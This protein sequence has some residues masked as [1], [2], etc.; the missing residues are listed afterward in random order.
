MV[1]LTLAVAAVVATL[2]TLL[3]WAARPPGDAGV[4]EWAARYD[5]ALRLEDREPVRR[6]LRRGRLLRTGGFVVPFAIWVGTG[7]YWTAV[8]ERPM[9][10]FPLGW[11]ANPAAWATGYLVG[12]VVAELTRPSGRRQPVRGAALVPRRLADYVP[13]WMPWTARGLAAAI[14]VLAQ[15]N[16]A[17]D[18]GGSDP[19]PLRPSFIAAFAAV[20]VTV[21]I[22]VALRVVVRRPQ[23]V[24]S[25]AELSVDD[26]LR[27]SS[28][29]RIAGA[30]MAALM[31]LLANQLGVLPRHWWAVGALLALV[32]YGLAIGCWRDLT[33]P[34]WWP[35][36]RGR[37]RSAP[38]PREPDSPP[39]PGPRR[40]PA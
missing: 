13:A 19:W 24:A 3:L 39:G 23:P 18:A 6:Q 7:I 30:G 15:F 21:L 36:R 29:H 1:T 28:V 5:L 40:R 10:R 14:V 34:I 16:H 12:A 27:S 4:L 8:V 37:S 2:T 31:F 35:V 17:D 38:D 33:S 22:E 25:T 9:P 11:I 20:A 26:A 32:C